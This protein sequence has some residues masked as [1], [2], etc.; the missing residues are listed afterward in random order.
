MLNEFKKFYENHL[1]QHGDSAQGV[2]WKNKEAQQVRFEQLIKVINVAENFSL[3]DLGCGVG[4]F[5]SFL[6][7]KN[8][9]FAYSGYDVIAEMIERANERFKST[10]QVTFDL[11]KKT[12]EMKVADFSIASGIFNIRFTQDDESWLQYILE[13]I[14]TM[15]EKS[16]AGFAFNIL[17]KYSDTEFMKPELYYADP[18]FL[19][20]YC[21]KNF[22]KNVALLH[23]YNQYDFTV[24]VR[25]N[26]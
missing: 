17:T 23:D 2:G 15:N 10:P 8:M 25:K 13:T 4:D 21:K 26:L 19:F 3:N 5:I 6:R 9:T 7:L 22:S 18:G 20:D 24:I 11:I 12:D 1:T 16:T 14:K